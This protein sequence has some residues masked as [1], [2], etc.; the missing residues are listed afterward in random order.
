MNTDE[1]N[2][3]K[4]IKSKTNLHRAR[5][6]AESVPLEPNTAETPF[7][8]AKKQKK[9]LSEKQLSQRRQ[10]A[11]SRV[12][13]QKSRKQLGLQT[14]EEVI[15]THDDL[16]PAE[17]Q[18]NTPAA[19]ELP[20]ESG[21]QNLPKI[22]LFDQMFDESEREVMVRNHE[23]LHKLFTL[24]TQTRE[25]KQQRDPLALSAASG[26]GLQQGVFLTQTHF[27]YY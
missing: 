27:T 19:E 24:R 4:Q 20:S 15:S 16:T 8:P 3:S 6:P 14:L 7:P 12:E 10:A 9:Q 2:N 17:Q 13:K 25:Y 26:R 23:R 11:K 22:T 5:H 21:K 18:F 1:S